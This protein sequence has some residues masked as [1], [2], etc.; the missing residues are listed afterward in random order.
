M[1]PALQTPVRQESKEDIERESDKK[2]S[3]EQTERML[4][5]VRKR[6]RKQKSKTWTIDPVSKEP[7]L[8]KTNVLKVSCDGTTCIKTGATKL[9]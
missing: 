2:L 5:D 3:R 9:D 1:A 6:V 7:K 8:L 4:V